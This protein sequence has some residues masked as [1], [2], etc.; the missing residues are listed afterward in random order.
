METRNINN[1]LIEEYEIINQNVQNIKIIISELQKLLN[2]LNKNISLR[3][4][5]DLEKYHISERIKNAFLQMIGKCFQDCRAE[6]HEDP[7]NN[8]TRIH[9][10]KINS[11]NKFTFEGKATLN[12]SGK[13]KLKSFDRKNEW[14][15]KGEVINFMRDGGKGILERGNKI[16]DGIWISDNLYHGQ[17]SWDD[18]KNNKSD[19]YS[20]GLRSL[21][22]YNIGQHTIIENNQFAYKY[23][24]EWEWAKKHGKGKIILSDK[25]VYDGEFQENLLSGKGIISL[26]TLDYVFN[27]KFK[28]GNPD[29]YCEYTFGDQRNYKLCGKWESGKFIDGNLLNT[30]TNLYTP[31]SDAS[32]ISLY[33]EIR[34]PLDEL[35]YALEELNNKKYNYY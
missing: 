12:Y 21:N 4:N 17:V 24:G 30:H 8:P 34:K 14:S 16:Y 35:N 31:I 23:D 33:D 19:T 22:P 15:Y 28:Y 26:L 32:K 1:R 6:N 11:D 29:G 3:R 7:T 20:G 2:Y 27:G 9:Q 18:M 10:L 5:I 13:G 25:I